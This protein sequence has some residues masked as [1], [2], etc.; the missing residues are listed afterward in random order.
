[1]E[2]PTP[3]T[4]EAMFSWTFYPFGWNNGI[5]CS[6]STSFT[7]SHDSVF[8]WSWHLDQGYLERWKYSGQSW[9]WFQGRVSQNSLTGT[10]NA[11]SNSIKTWS[12][13]QWPGY[14]SLDIT[15]NSNT[16]QELAVALCTALHKFYSLASVG[17]TFE[18][19]FLPELTESAENTAC[20]RICPLGPLF[21]SPL[22]RYHAQVY[23]L[24]R[25]CMGSGVLCT[26]EVVVLLDS[27]SRIH[28]YNT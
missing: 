28:V 12:F 2:H 26:P 19:G 8:W 22:G 27:L 13:T 7:W 25:W 16:K 14:D 4:Y 20:D 10:L 9:I 17:D 6:S 23:T 11:Y 18:T 21:T 3:L 5:S 24:E 1:M 15:I